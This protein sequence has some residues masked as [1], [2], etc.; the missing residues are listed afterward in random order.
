MKTLLFKLV[1][2]GS[3]IVLIGGAGLWHGYSTCNDAWQLQVAKDRAAWEAKVNAATV[4]S[5]ALRVTHAAELELKD[6]QIVELTNA[7]EQ[8][9]SVCFGGADANRV[10]DLWQ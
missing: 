2:S 10:R 7:L 1:A 8:P 5:E 9:D 3:A 4:E 6:A